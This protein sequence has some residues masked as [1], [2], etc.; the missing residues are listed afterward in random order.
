MDDFPAMMFKCK[1]VIA[2][3]QRGSTLEEGCL[4]LL[5]CAHNQL[6]FIKHLGVAVSNWPPSVFKRLG[7]VMT[8]LF[9]SSLSS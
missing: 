2:L 7:L 4:L 1:L 9:G 6:P 3:M 5:L 8:N